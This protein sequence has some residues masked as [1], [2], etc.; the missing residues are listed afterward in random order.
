[1]VSPC[2]P[3]PTVG[4]GVAA[5]RAELTARGIGPLQGA[6]GW[7]MAVVNVSAELTIWLRDGHFTVPALGCYPL[8]DAVE[9]AEQV[10]R[11]TTT[12]QDVQC[13]R[14]TTGATENPA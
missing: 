14:P 8:T 5:L 11:L 2:R 9:V 13:P 12:G 1:M 10:I 6:D 3:T 7:G 4:E